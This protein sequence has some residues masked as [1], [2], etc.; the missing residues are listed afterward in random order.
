MLID[1]II[2]YISIPAVSVAFA[3]AFA[4]CR[5]QIPVIK[6]QIT[7]SSSWAGILRKSVA[8]IGAAVA[9]EKPAQAR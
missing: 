6:G 4:Y 1:P 2:V 8:H 5:T 7:I 9:C 3:F